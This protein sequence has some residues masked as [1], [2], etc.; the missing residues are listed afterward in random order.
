MPS[1]MFPAAQQQIRIKSFRYQHRRLLTETLSPILSGSDPF[2]Q[3]NIFPIR[4]LQTIRSRLRVLY[5]FMQHRNSGLPTNWAISAKTLLFRVLVGLIFRPLAFRASRFVGSSSGL[6][7]YWHTTIT[8]SS[9]MDGQQYDAAHYP[10]RD[11]APATANT[12]FR[13]DFTDASGTCFSKDGSQGSYNETQDEAIQNQC[14]PCKYR[15][16]WFHH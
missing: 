11:H 14:T 4:H 16:R 1:T 3:R 5:H 9:G 2:T 10:S 13:S 8:V 12:S 7:S 15:L 6:D